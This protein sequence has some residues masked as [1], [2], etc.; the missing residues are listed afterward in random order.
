METVAPGNLATLTLPLGA[1][2][3]ATEKLLIFKF[4]RGVGGCR[5]LLYAALETDSWSNVV[6]MVLNLIIMLAL[7]I[8][9]MF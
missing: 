9:V 2:K 7:S 5:V 8:E 6:Y 1:Q 3:L 4:C